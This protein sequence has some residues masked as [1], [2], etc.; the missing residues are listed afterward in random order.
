MSG[1]LNLLHPTPYKL[2]PMKE[3]LLSADYTGHRPVTL[4][5]D[6]PLLSTIAA[7]V[8][9]QLRPYSILPGL[10]TLHP[11]TSLTLQAC[12]SITLLVTFHS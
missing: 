1:H 10:A 6:H 2:D 7:Q 5:R 8:R 9:L 11:Y 3:N 4:R 12:S